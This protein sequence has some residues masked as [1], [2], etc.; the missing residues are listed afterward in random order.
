MD[1]VPTDFRRVTMLV[2][3]IEPALEIYRDI[4]GMRVHYDQEINVFGWSLPSPEPNARARLVILKC[5]HTDIGMLGLLHYL[6]QPLAEA[7]PTPGPLRAGSTVFVMQNENVEEAHQKLKN[8]EGVQIVAEPHVTEFPR[9]DGGVFRVEG[10]SFFDPNGY[11][12]ELNQIV[13]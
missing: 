4:L 6:D 2:N 8:V 12:V 5:N 9:G 13:E 7:G 11:F 10:F 1:K 3:R